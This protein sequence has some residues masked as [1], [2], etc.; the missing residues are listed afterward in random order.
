M[1]VGKAASAFL[2]F[3]V[4]HSHIIS[5]ELASV[6]LHDLSPL[7]ATLGCSQCSSNIVLEDMRPLSRNQH[8]A[9]VTAVTSCDNRCQAVDGSIW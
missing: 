1:G 5:E 6:A 3:K 9:A 2:L 4:S 8:D 7:F